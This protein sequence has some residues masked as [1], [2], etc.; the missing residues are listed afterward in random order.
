MAGES[1][2]PVGEDEPISPYCSDP[3]CT[4]CKELREAY[5]DIRKRNTATGLL[6]SYRG[7]VPACPCSSLQAVTSC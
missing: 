4:S 1:I 3:N 5:A 2:L 7:I 6:A